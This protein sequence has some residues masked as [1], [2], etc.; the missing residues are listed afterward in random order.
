M[1]DFPEAIGG[2]A[3]AALTGR[4]AEPR[5]GEGAGRGHTAETACLNCG[6]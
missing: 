1:S 5:R 2:L 3:E 6:T 4:A